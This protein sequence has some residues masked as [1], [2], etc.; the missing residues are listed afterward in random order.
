MR[1][2]MGIALVVFLLRG[3]NGTIVIVMW[4]GVFGAETENKLGS[5]PAVYPVLAI[6]LDMLTEILKAVLTF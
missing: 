5:W 3:W 6:F 1:Q 4:H 2:W